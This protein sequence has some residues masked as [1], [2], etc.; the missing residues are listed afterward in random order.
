MNE[1]ET[2]QQR[3]RARK[4]QQRRRRRIFLLTLSGLLAVIAFALLFK[5]NQNIP[6][7]KPEDTQVE[8]EA[9][10][11]EDMQV[12]Y[13]QPAEKEADLLKAAKISDGVRT[14]YLTFDDGPTKSVTPRVLDTLRRYQVKATFFMVGS[15]I[16]QNPDMARRVYDEGHFLANHSYSHSYSKLYANETDFMN[17]IN[18][19]YDLIAGIEGKSVKNRIFRFP[20]G[21]YNAGTWGANKQ[22]YKGK[23]AENGIRYCDWNALNGDAEGGTRTAAEL[24]ERVKK[25]TGAEDVVILMHDAAAKSTTADALPQVIEY[26]I[27]QGFV[28]KTLAQI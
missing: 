4:R 28:F 12:I 13:P 17:E 21:G 23:L 26:L 15:L 25:T 7:I 10:K 24:L 8:A 27:G 6:M 11:P 3:R 5:P 1:F 9:V 20:G 18:I 14:C 22:I 19:T 2:R 16:E